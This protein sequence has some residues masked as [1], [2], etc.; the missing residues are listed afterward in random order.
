MLTAKDL[1]DLLEEGPLLK[2][3]FSWK[4]ATCQHPMYLLIDED[5]GIPTVGERIPHWGA[6]NAAE[7]VERVRRNLDSLEKYPDLKLNYQF[8]GAEMEAMAE[9]FPDVVKWMKKHYAEGSLDFL[10]GSFSQPH[11]QVLGAESNWRQFEYGLEVF[12]KIFG[13]VKL[14]AGDFKSFKASE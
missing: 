1:R 6:P 13:F 10:D 12:Q 14:P 4:L 11:L 2:K 9:N 3:H 5:R 7:Y 8:S